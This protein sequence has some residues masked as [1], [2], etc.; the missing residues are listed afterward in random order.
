MIKRKELYNEVAHLTVSKTVEVRFNEVDSL[1]IVWHGHYI[2]YFEDG[3]EAFGK[4][5]GL[6]YLTVEASGYTTPIVK[7]VCEHKL[8]LRYGESFRI[9]TTF[10]DTPTAKLIFRYKIFNSEERLVCTGETVQ[11]FLGQD[12]QMILNTPDF[13][14]DWKKKIGLL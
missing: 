14:L 8:P 5:H 12:D 13:V 7:S 4:Q 3:R 1:R 11:V 9:E 2:T 10:V 6:D